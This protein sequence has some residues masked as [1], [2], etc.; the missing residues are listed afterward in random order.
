MADSYPQTDPISVNNR[1]VGYSSNAL[2]AQQTRNRMVSAPNYQFMH[3]HSQLNTAHFPLNNDYNQPA[4]F[5]LNVP[6]HEFVPIQPQMAGNT[7]C[8]KG[9]LQGDQV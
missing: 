8:F 1:L 7:V 6:L 2:Y 9:L 3:S 5:N 4:N